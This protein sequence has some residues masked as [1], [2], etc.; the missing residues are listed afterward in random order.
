MADALGTRI[1]RGAMHGADAWFPMDDLRREL[2]DVLGSDYAVVTEPHVQG[3]ELDALLVGPHGIYVLATINWEGRV[4][5]M[6][7]GR[8]EVTDSDGHTTSYPNPA[9]RAQ[10][11]VRAVRHFMRDEFPRRSVPI[12]AL[13]VLVSPNAEIETYGATDPPVVTLDN[14]RQEI[15]ALRRPGSVVSLE[16]D[17]VR[18]LA[19]ALG[20]R[21]LTRR[22]KA[23]Q[24]FVFRSGGIFGSGRKVWTIRAAV[25][26]MD[27]HPD[28][29]AYHLRNGTLERWLRDQGARHLARLV[30][31][32]TNQREADPRI[33]VEQFLIGTGLV[34]RPRLRLSP[35]RV[36]L[37]YVLPGEES[38]ARCRVRK[39]LGRGYLFGTVRTEEPW[40]RVEPPRF[41][42]KSELMVWASSETLSIQRKP[43]VSH[44]YLDTS[45]SEDPLE[46]PARLRVVS[47]PHRINR[48]VWR[49]LVGLVLGVVFGAALGVLLAQRG[50]GVPKLLKRL[51]YAGAELPQLAF[52]VAVGVAW[53]LLGAWRGFRQRLAWPTGY[54]TVRWL[55]RLGIWAIALGAIAAA[56]LAAL[57]WVAAVPIPLI[58]TTGLLLGLAALA[59]ANVPATVSEVRTSME[60]ASTDLEAVDRRAMRPLI[61]ALVGVGLIVLLGAATFAL[62]PIYRDLQA[63]DVA[64]TVQSWVGDRATAFGDWIDAA[65]D[66]IYLDRY[67]R[68]APTRVPTESPGEASVATSPTVAPAEGD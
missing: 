28:D 37:G 12:H 34:R 7:T 14:L 5:T 44:I 67:D 2:R 40:L 20:E 9:P 1:D 27:R 16:P 42:G 49:P 62:E 11:G 45:A 66:R 25:R 57:V 53:G 58:S 17:E 54:V 21:E 15:T 48:W 32:V 63:R 6:R 30:R 3:E 38:V 65:L 26:H 29:G 59:L 60:E 50:M 33:A 47:M 64:S 19:R 55:L 24:P 18:E 31:E 68:R 52:G 39:G 61:S 46:V 36:D 8:W 41:V 23:S 43:H 13:L 56:G 10:R 22:Q 4:R 35:R 51:G